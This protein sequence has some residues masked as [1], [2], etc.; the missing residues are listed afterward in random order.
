MKL[1][2]IA[3]FTGYNGPNII[4]IADRL[5]HLLGQDEIFCPIV[6]ERRYNGKKRIFYEVDVPLFF[7]YVFIHSE[8]D[9]GLEDTIDTQVSDRCDFIRFGEDGKWA[10]ITELEMEQLKSDHSKLI[11]GD[12]ML[13]F[14]LKPGDFV[15]FK[16][17]PFANF[18]G[19]ILVIIPAKSMAKVVTSIFNND[20]IAEVAINSLE[21][22]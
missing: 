2:Y 9:P 10:G 4:K 19:K 22:V 13:D 6:K 20:T 16:A 17:G 8:F 21:K 15:R 18:T 3:H 12:E 14:T 1:W 5:K 7:G 11:K